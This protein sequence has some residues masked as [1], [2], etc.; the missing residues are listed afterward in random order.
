MKRI[1]LLTF[2]VGL[3]SYTHAQISV[4]IDSAGNLMQQQQQ[5][6]QQHVVEPDRLL[7]VRSVSQ[8]ECDARRSND[9]VNKRRR[10]R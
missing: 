1:A 9:D 4:S 3:M 5:Q 8:S 6:Q 7:R 10:S 2:L